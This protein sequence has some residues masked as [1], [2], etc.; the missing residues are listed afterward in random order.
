MHYP[1]PV[2][3]LSCKESQEFRS[4]WQEG[5]ELFRIRTT[6]AH[7]QR[8]T[9]LSSMK[10][11]RQWKILTLWAVMPVQEKPKAK[12]NPSPLPQTQTTSLH[13]HLKS[14]SGSL[15]V[16]SLTFCRG[17]PL[18]SY[19]KGERSRTNKAHSNWNEILTDTVFE[20][21][22]KQHVTNLHTHWTSRN[23]KPKWPM[24]ILFFNRYIW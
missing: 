11:R 10:F 3:C 21:D 6:L 16:N 4:S 20:I 7:K 24:C 17:K 22:K 9:F 2:C 12:P 19:C 5:R 1:N 15:W 18:Q 14:K 23:K 13:R 8:D